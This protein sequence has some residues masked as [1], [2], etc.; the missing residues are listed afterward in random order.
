MPDINALYCAAIPSLTDHRE[1]LSCKFFKSVR[2]PSSCLSSLLPNPRD[3]S[4]TTRL[5]FANKLPRLCS[6]MKKISD[7]YFRYSVSLSNSISILQPSILVFCSFFLF[8]AFLFDCIYLFVVLYVYL[9]LYYY[10]CYY[11]YWVYLGFAVGLPVVLLE[12][13]EAVLLQVWYPS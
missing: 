1:Q 9:V 8:L 3:P 7:I 5:S 10:Y 12:I 6:C 13:A 11:Y 4:V 2:E